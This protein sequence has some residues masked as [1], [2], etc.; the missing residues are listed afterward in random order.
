MRVY[1]FVD[2]IEFT[3]D[4]I[5]KRLGIAMSIDE[6]RALILKKMRKYRI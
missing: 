2:Y 5:E 3:I 4:F 1:D 6:K